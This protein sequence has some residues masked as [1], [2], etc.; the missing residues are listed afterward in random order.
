MIQSVHSEGGQI[1][2]FG[3]K[4]TPYMIVTGKMK[5][6]PFLIEGAHVFFIRG[7]HSF[8]LPVSSIYGTNWQKEFES[9]FSFNW[10]DENRV[11]GYTFEVSIEDEIFSKWLKR[12]T[13][14]IGEK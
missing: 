7:E 4:R 8:G 11:T 3:D 9:D 2:V 12:A 14:R 13:C 1:L 10:T 5:I 6:E